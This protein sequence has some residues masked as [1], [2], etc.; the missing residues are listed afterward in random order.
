VKEKNLILIDSLQ[1]YFGKRPD[2]PFKR[3]LANHA[4]EIGK[5]GLSILGEIG[6]YPYKS[7]SDDL[8]DYESSLPAKFDLPMKGFCLYHED[9]QMSKNES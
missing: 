1:E 5:N 9:F 6:A 8:V 2:M 3:S 7:K 4:K